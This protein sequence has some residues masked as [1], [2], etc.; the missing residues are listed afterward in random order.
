MRLLFPTI[1]G[2][3]KV[4][5]LMVAIKRSNIQAFEE[6]KKIE[7]PISEIAALNFIGNEHPNLIHLIECCT[8]EENNIY[9]VVMAYYSQGDLFELIHTRPRPWAWAYG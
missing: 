6:G 3:V 9:S 8:D 2:E 7:N 4:G 5:L 1:Y